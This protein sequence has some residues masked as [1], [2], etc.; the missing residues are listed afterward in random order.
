MVLCS[1]SWKFL[2][3]STIFRAFSRNEA[4]FATVCWKIHQNGKTWYFAWKNESFWPNRRFFVLF[5]EMRHF[6]QLFAKKFSKTIKHGILFEKVKV[7][8]QIDH[9]WCFFTKWGTFCDFLLKSSPKRRN[10]IICI[11]KL[12]VLYKS[13]IP[14]SCS[15]NEALFRTF[16]WKVAQSAKSCSLFEK[17]E[18]FGQIDDFSCFFTNWGTF[19][20]IL[21]KSSPK[22]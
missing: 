10:I 12:K 7:F 14:R 2:A 11:E 3:K 17:L 19:C 21:L 18:V 5:Y 4:L 8:G 13:M 1:K 20:D 15:R 22:A 6:L 9:F 16:C